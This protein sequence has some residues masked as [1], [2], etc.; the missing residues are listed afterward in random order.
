MTLKGKSGSPGGL[1][2][3]TGALTPVLATPHYR[4]QGGAQARDDFCPRVPG[5]VPPPSALS[6][7]VGFRGAGLAWP[8][9][10]TPLA[11]LKKERQAAASSHLGHVTFH[12]F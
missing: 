11:G 7:P 1:P 12:L 5:S 3:G 8:P 9:L 10:S 2:R 6:R 4:G